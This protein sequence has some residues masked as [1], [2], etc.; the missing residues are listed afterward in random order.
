MNP[1]LPLLLHLVQVLGEVRDVHRVGFRPLHDPDGVRCGMPGSADE[2][3]CSSSLPLPS[4]LGQM[5]QQQEQQ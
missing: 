1:S 3:M 2:G 5:Q 4:S